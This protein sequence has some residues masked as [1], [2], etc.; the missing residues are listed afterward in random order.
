MVDD[1]DELKEGKKNVVNKSKSM[2]RSPGT[3]S[4]PDLATLV[5]KAKEAKDTNKEAK[6]PLPAG[7]PASSVKS[8]APTAK[9]P[10]PQR[11]TNAMVNSCSSQSYASTSSSRSRDRASSHTSGP[12]GEDSWDRLSNGNLM[13]RPSGKRMATISEGSGRR[14]RQ[15]SGEDGFKVSEEC[16]RS[17]AGLI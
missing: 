6:P 5:R 2:F 9:S 16:G 14:S 3:A 4:S 13:N 15:S 17:R 7:S 1:L 10:T 12:G 11:P 8:S